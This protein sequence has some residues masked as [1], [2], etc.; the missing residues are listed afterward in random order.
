MHSIWCFVFFRGADISRR[1]VWIVRFF[2]QIWKFVY[3]KT[4]FKSDLIFKIKYY[5]Y[6]CITC[7]FYKVI[8]ETNRN[9]F[10]KKNIVKLNGIS[11]YCP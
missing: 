8:A 6:G 11:R 10:I 2:I 4:N 7:M 1:D 3:S 5:D 9:F